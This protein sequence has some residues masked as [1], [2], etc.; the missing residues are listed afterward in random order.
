M[1]VLKT[2]NWSIEN[3]KT[4]LFDKDG[5]FIDINYF[6]GRMTELRVDEI[7]KNFNL[8]P[9]VFKELCLCLGYDTDLKKMKPD[10][11]TALYSRV[12]IIEIFKSD[13]EKFGIKTTSIKLEE[14]FDNVS[15]SF[16][17]NI[18]K[19]TK[20]IDE[21]ITFIKRVKS[22]GIQTG[23]VTSD[24][25][26]STELTLKNF[27]WDNYFDIVIGR[28]SSPKTK[29]SGIPTLMAI[30]KL[31]ANPKTTIMIGDAPMDYISAK[32]AGI[33]KTILVSTGQISLQELKN[34]SNYV[35]ESLSNISIVQN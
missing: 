12:K 28:E 23:I 18:T 34:T 10:G 16:Y 32:N 4:I 19:Y 30:E 17:Q 8:P 21:A 33:E 6:W 22:I 15:E 5:T 26:K 9:S 27:N 20:P 35:I 7:I 11:I 25:I 24:S 1:I 31:K 14:I 29:E 13:L 3:V 2:N